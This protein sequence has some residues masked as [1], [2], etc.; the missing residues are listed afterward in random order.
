MEM[1]CFLSGVG[2]EVLVCNLEGFSLQTV[3]LVSSKVTSCPLNLVSS[4]QV[5]VMCLLQANIV[6]PRSLSVPR[7]TI[8]VG[9]GLAVWTTLRITRVSV[10]WGILERTVLST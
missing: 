5:T 1:E 9:M 10:W 2:N 6:R 7:S 4:L 8:R 3:L